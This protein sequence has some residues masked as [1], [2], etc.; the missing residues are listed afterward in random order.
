MAK[1]YHAGAKTGLEILLAFVVFALVMGW[2]AWWSPTPNPPVCS[3][4]VT[5]NITDEEVLGLI[6]DCRDAVPMTDETKARESID[7][8]Q[9]L[10]RRL[11]R[12]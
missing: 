10:M 3:I 12:R 8:R 11:R 1:P 6:L 5:E 7:R 2:L 9:A 4:Q